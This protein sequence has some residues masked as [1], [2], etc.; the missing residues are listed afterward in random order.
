MKKHF[1]EFFSPG[2]FVSEVDVKPIEKWD[3]G[4]AVKMASKITQRYGARPYGFRFITRE[5]GPKDLD[6]SVSKRS[7]LYYLGGRIETL[8][9]VEARNDPKEKILLSNMKANG[10][11]KIVINENSY[12]STFPLNKGDVILPVV[13]P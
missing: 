2:T 8:A 13:L 10:Y 7:G 11:E 4:I 9:Q 6:S 3:A 5:R 12:R 1:V